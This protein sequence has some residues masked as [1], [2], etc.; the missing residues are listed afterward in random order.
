MT[1][2]ALSLG[3]PALVRLHDVLTCLSKFS[4]TVAIEAEHSAVC[5]WTILPNWWTALTKLNHLKLRLSV[6]N[7]TKTA[8][9]SFVCE[10]DIFFESYSFQVRTDGRAS[11]QNQ[12]Q[13]QERFYCQILIKVSLK[14][15]VLDNLSSYWLGGRHFSLYSE[16]ESIDIRI[17]LLNAVR[18]SS[19]K[20]RIKPNAD[21]LSRWF[22][23]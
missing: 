8:F 16:G 2:L 20:N 18:W 14:L 6:L 15:Q 4:D 5:F 21:W 1:S 11:Y 19:T 13:G 9:A 3:P 10:K 23:V 22:V 12:N 7:S 17:Q